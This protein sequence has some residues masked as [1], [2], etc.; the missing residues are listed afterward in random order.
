MIR[1]LIS[2][3]PSPLFLTIHG[4]IP[5]V[6]HLFGRG[7][8]LEKI[9]RDYQTLKVLSEDRTFADLLELALLIVELCI[10]DG[11]PIHHKLCNE[12]EEDE[13]NARIG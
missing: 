8:K 4:S 13:G 11:V 10:E 3:P 2:P 9:L 6:L 12:E 5:R 1:R 7:E